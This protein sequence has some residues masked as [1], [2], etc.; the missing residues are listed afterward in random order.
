MATHSRRERI[1]SWLLEREYEYN[2]GAS[3]VEIPWS[4]IAR[5]ASVGTLLTLLGISLDK[6]FILASLFLLFVFLLGRYAVH[7][8][9]SRKRN[10]IGNRYNPDLQEIK[11]RVKYR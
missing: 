6:L 9:V 1:V 11:E 5:G 8:G 10:A 4:I 2:Q 7:V 3:I